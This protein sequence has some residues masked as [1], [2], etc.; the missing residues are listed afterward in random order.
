LIAHGGALRAAARRYGCPVSD[1]LDLS[2]GIN[3]RGYPVPPLSADCWR[4]LPEDDDGLEEA[5][6]ACYRA[7]R[8]LA[9]PGSQRAIELLPTLFPPGRVLLLAPSYEEHAAAWQ[10]AGHEPIFLPALEAESGLETAA[11]GCDTVLLCHPNNPTGQRFR[12]ERLLDL[13]QHLARRG[14]R[15]VVDEAFM[16]A[17]PAESL[18]GFSSEPGIIVLRSLG[19]FFGLAGARVGFVL[20]EDG[21]LDRLRE[22]LGPWPVAGPARAVA[23]AALRDHDWHEATRQ[24]LRQ[25]GERLAELLRASGLGEPRGTP[26]FQ[27]LPHP[28]AARIHDRLAR[29]AILVRQF[30]QPASLRFGLPPDE[31]G[32]QR[33]AGAL[34]ELQTGSGLSA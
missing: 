21:L 7:P 11:A 10:C 5:A 24:R 22:A 2:T 30:P 17:D 16:D 8:A 13:G 1:W 32:W 29:Q 34:N 33:L 27:W 9:V 4:R 20:A 14:G 23:L 6:A 19:K 15:L 25:E 3:P 26:L 12:R 28:E 18:A 31:A